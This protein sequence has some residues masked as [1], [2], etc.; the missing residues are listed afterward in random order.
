MFKNNILWICA[1]DFAT[2]ACSPYGNPLVQTPA[3]DRLARVGIRFDRAYCPAPLSTPSRLSFLTGKYPWTLGVTLPPTP[4][5]K[6]ETTIAEHLRNAGYFT[7]A[8]GKT[9]YYSHLKDRF[10]LA[11]D[12]TDHEQWLGEQGY[13]QTAAFDTETLPPWHPFADSAA[14]WLNSMG[15]PY[16]ARDEQMYGT[17]LANQTAKFLA[18]SHNQPFFAYVAFHETHSPFRFPV[19]FEYRCDP[20]LIEPP[21]PPEDTSEL[22][23]VFADLTRENKQG[24]IASYFTCASFMDKN[25]GLILDALEENHLSSNTLVIFSS[26]HGYLLGQRGRFEKHCCYEPAIRVPLLMRFPDG[27]AAGTSSDL[28]VSLIDIVPTL[29]EFCGLESLSDLPGRSLLPL[30]SGGVDP[31]RKFVVSHYSNNEEACLVEDRLKVI[32]KTGNR[33]RRDGYLPRVGPSGP[34]V[35]LYDLQNDPEEHR[36]LASEYVYYRRRG[37]KLLD[38]LSDE[39]R[40]A[41]HETTEISHTMTPLQALNECLKPTPRERSFE[42]IFVD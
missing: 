42:N 12:H 10:D 35:E 32:Y 17:Y 36:N 5:P 15:W 7:A 6:H 21:D 26:D 28:L 14:I 33:R 24:I 34:T 4:L 18:Q 38:T 23:T 13:G 19:D 27:A 2:Q 31:W 30:I 40:S 8:F 29:L 9:H 41:A 25:V 20:N 1:D 16:G 3:L 11:L 22:P 37:L 39:M